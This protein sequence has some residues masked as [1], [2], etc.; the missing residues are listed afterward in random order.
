MNNSVH[1][2]GQALVYGAPRGSEPGSVVRTPPDRWRPMPARQSGEAVR[3][4]QAASAV[5][6]TT[7]ARPRV[8]TVGGACPAR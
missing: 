2:S 3:A 7:H 4:D 8:P 6:G 5:G 1:N